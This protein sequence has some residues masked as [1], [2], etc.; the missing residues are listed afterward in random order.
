MHQISSAKNLAENVRDLE[1]KTNFHSDSLQK[2][3]E[4][5]QPFLK[6]LKTKL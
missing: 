4:S 5:T 3:P 2:S 1:R 6:K